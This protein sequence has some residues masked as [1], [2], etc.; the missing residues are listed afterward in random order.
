MLKYPYPV[1]ALLS[2]RIAMDAVFV[3]GWAF[4]HERIVLYGPTVRQ[5]SRKGENSF[6]I[7]VL[8]DYGVAASIR[9]YGTVEKGTVI[10][11]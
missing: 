11:A 6:V 5:I 4:S 9:R 2:M 3:E 7:S 10:G 8:S 1:P